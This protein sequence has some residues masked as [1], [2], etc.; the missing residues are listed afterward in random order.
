MTAV[1]VEIRNCVALID[2][3]PE[4]CESISAMMAS[5]GL[6]IAV[7]R[8][9]RDFLDFSAMDEFGCVITDLRL[10]DISGL[11]VVD[12]VVEE[13]G[14]CPPAIMISGYADVRT[15]VSAIKG[16][17]IDFL[18]KPFVPQDLIDQVQQALVIDQ[19][20]RTLRGMSKRLRDGLKKLTEREKEVLRSLLDCKSNKQISADLNLSSKTV[21]SHRANIL[22]KCETE[23]LLELAGYMQA[24]ELVV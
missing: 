19:E 13:H 5:I 23:S 14:Y 20:K 4:M 21:A 12:R 15:A 18:E 2:D 7:F 10:P 1:K 9:G 8:N 11:Q 6:R 17:M 16:G 22:T 24:C 3:D